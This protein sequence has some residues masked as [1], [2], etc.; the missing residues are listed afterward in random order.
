MRVL[1]SLFAQMLIDYIRFGTDVL[2]RTRRIR[3]K[4]KKLLFE[5]EGHLLWDLRLLLFLCLFMEE[6]DAYVSV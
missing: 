4:S 1:Q 6:G 2:R 3:V 5:F